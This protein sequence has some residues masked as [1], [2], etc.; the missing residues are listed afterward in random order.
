MTTTTFDSH[1]AIQDLKAAGASDD[2]A[3]A[4]VQIIGDSAAKDAMPRNESVDR[5]DISLAISTVELR[6]TKRF[7]WISLGVLGVSIFSSVVMSVSLLAG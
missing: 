5:T 3:R 1:K 4:V 6:I 2:L 7:A